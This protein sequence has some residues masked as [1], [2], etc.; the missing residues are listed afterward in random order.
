MTE[1]LSPPTPPAKRDWLWHPA[2]IVFVS[3]ICIMVIELVAGRMVAPIIG[4]SLYTWTSIIGVILAGISV[5]N[6]LGGKLADRYASR[7]L[8]GGLFV[9]SGLG[10]ISVLFTVE[11]L[12]QSG[13][14]FVPIKSLIVRMV[15]FISAI[16]FLPSLL[17]GLISPVVI[18]LSLND[19]RA[20]GN[21]IG[22]IY[23][24]SALGSIVGTFAT[25]YFLI[26]WIG[27]RAISLG[28]GVLLLTMGLLLGQWF[29]RRAPVAV[30]VLLLGLGAGALVAGSD[31]FARAMDSGCLVESNYFCIKVG[32]DTQNG[33]EYRVLSLDALVHSYNA[34]DDPA[35]LRYS[36]E[37]VGAEI[38]Q[39]VQ[40]RDRTIEMLLI[41]G[42]G[43]TL[44]RYLQTAYPAAR[45]D[46]AEIDPAVTGI[47]FGALGVPPNP[48]VRTFNE[49]AR[50][51]L[52]E[53]DPGKRYNYIHGD[54]FNDFSVPYHLTTQEFNVLV[55]SHLTPGGIYLVNLIDGLDAP[56][57]RAYLRT[58]RATF[59]YVYF[60]PTNRAYLNLRANTMLALATDAPLNL[61]TLRTLNGHDEISQ[62]S[63]WVL[64][65]AELD[66]WLSQGER[67][68]L[69]D[70]YVPADNLLT[71]VFE[72]KLAL[73][74]KP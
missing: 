51:F 58:L 13:L 72:V 41:G 40:G 10:A 28:V 8:L 24:A 53:L 43:Y 29:K 46:V 32:H 6:F 27:T 57:A 54:A 2:L 68:I 23:A 19:L 63:A 44:P 36:Y 7:Q 30:L 31:S 9:L 3:N 34:V 15:L 33:K 73:A 39:Y 22:R 50:Q 65:D 67:F 47:A 16:Y 64:S 20:T 14:T 25:G 17:L 18:K 66:D 48:Q 35:D 1:P 45:V 59:K 37:Q 38:A 42:G 49:D 4:V 74:D 21:V 55:R 62:F 60:V 5:G 56:F 69:T 11:A 52:V 12:S 26:S 61:E 70:D 71:G